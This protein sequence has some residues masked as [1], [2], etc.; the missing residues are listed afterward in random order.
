MAYIVPQ[1]LPYISNDELDRFLEAVELARCEC[2]HVMSSHA[3]N[4]FMCKFC[5][6]SEWKPKKR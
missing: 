1:S 2:D 4:E 6:C 5:H 3:Y